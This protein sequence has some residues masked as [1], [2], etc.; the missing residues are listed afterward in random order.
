MGVE[1]EVDAAVALER[2]HVQVVVQRADLVDP[3][4]L[5]ERLDHLE[6]RMRPRVDPA[7][8][9]EQLA[10]KRVCGDALPHARRPVEEVGVRRAVRECRLEQ[11]LRLALL[12]NVSEGGH[13]SPPRAPRSAARRRRRRTAVDRGPRAARYASAARAQ[14]ATPSRSIRSPLPPTR[15][16][17]GLGRDLDDHRPVGKQAA[18]DGEVELED[19][20]DPEVAATALVGDRRVDVPV[21]DDGCATLERGPDHL[22]DVLGASGGVERDL[23]PR[24]DVIAV[25]DEVA[26]LL[27]ERRPARLAREHDVD[28]LAL[29]RLG[30]EPRLGRL[31]GAV[32]ALEG[33]EHRQDVRPDPSRLLRCARSSPAGP[34]SSARTSSTRCSRAATTSSCSTTSRPVAATTSTG[35]R[36]SSSTTSASR[37]RP[38]PS[39]VFHLAAQADVGTSMER[40]GFDSEVN[41][42]GTVN[43][44]EAARAA[45]ARVVFSSTGG[46]IYGDVD[47]PG[48][49]DSALLPVSPY[50]LAKRSAEVYVD[51]WNRIFGARHVVLRFANVYGPRQSAALEGGVV[52]IFLERLAAGEPTTIFG[53]GTITRDFVHVD[54]VVRALARSPAIT[55][56][57]CSTSAQASRRPS[58][59]CTSSAARQSASTRHRASGRRAP[60]TRAAAC[61]TRRAPQRELGFTREGRLSP[62]GF[63]DDP[64]CASREGVAGRR[65]NPSSVDHPLDS[66]A[67]AAVRPVAHGDARRGT[68]SPPPSSCVLLVVG[69]AWLAKPDPSAPDRAREGDE[70]RRHA[71]AEGGA[72]A[73][74]DTRQGRTGRP[75]APQGQGRRPQRQRPPG[76]RRGHARRIE[77]RGYRISVVGNAP[78]HDYPTLARHVPPP[79]SPPRAAPRARSRHPARLAARRPATRPAAGAHTVVILGA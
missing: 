62:T 70:G 48:A 16:S 77:R 25:E 18:D 5:A 27:A 28:A 43:V 56:A 9:A 39:V 69:G 19:G 50:G 60:A 41:V 61:S 44:L 22:V 47:A 33:D 7:R 67:S 38:T 12:G 49:E 79:A 15:A 37:S 57:A 66:S 29:E 55:T 74:R 46:A 24:R 8:V 31:A 1:H 76:R 14:S 53:D 11:A 34:G 3:D 75:P 32:D 26:H 64:R 78:S 2:A 71:G 13:G 20:V 52:A 4:H 21:A 63:A 42:V 36:P 6:I 72:G 17:R 51:G 10:G 54:D 58:P 30:E 40:P 65:A 35:L 45:G 23:S 73:A 59:S 68:S